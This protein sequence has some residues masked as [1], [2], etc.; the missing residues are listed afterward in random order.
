MAGDFELTPDK[1]REVARFAQAAAQPVL[2][3]FE[4]ACPDDPLPRAALDAALRG[5]VR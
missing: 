1:L 5:R 4:D 3:V 2:S